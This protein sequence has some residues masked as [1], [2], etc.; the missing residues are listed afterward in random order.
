M[1][2][3]RIVRR[4]KNHPRAGHIV[5]NNFEHDSGHR[6]GSPAVLRY[7]QINLSRTPTVV[8]QRQNSITSD[9]NVEIQIT[10]RRVRSHA[11]LHCQP[12]TGINILPHWHGI[13]IKKCGTLMSSVDKVGLCNE[14]SSDE[15]IRTCESVKWD[16]MWVITFYCKAMLNMSSA[17]SVGNK[18]A[19]GNDDSIGKRKLGCRRKLSP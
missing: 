6:D 3:V 9:P 11:R 2:E 14:M 10:F 1:F 12:V 8:H 15:E 18:N 19:V 7:R 5:V 17:C 16:H 4:E 13:N